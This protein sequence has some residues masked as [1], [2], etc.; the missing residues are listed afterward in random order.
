MK[1]RSIEIGELINKIKGQEV[2]KRHVELPGEK[3]EHHAPVPEAKAKKKRSSKKPVVGKGTTVSFGAGGYAPSTAPKIQQDGRSFKALLATLSIG[4]FEAEIEDISVDRSGP[5][6]TMMDGG[7][8]K[9]MA[10]SETT[11]SVV[12]NEFGMSKAKIGSLSTDSMGQVFDMKV[13][14][15]SDDSQWRFKGFI[16]SMEREMIRMTNTIQI[17][18]SGEITAT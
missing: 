12:L 4:D 6:D 18:V 11:I 3:V 1:K 16:V 7:M 13:T 10:F 15:P 5:V 2:N 8:M 17:R 9:T 14:F